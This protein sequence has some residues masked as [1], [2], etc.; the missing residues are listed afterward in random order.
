[1]RNRYY[2]LTGIIA[3]F[4]FLIT[5]LPAAPVISMFE[6]RLPVEIKNISGTFW[7]GQAASI[8]T[9][10]DLVLKNVEWSFLPWRL[11]LASA[12][13]DVSAKLNNKPINTR[14]SAG[15][16]G[17]IT[18]ADLA[19]RLDASDV[20]PLLALPIGELAG[21]FQL[22]IDS[23][24]F[25]QGEVPRVD[26]T[27]NWNRA[28]VTV[29]ETAELGNVSILV[30]E[31][32]TSPLAARISNKG[33][34]ISL[35]GNFTTTEQGDYSLQLT[36]KPSNTASDNLVKTLAMFSRKQRNGEFVLNNKGNLSQLGLM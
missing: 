33:G 35:N 36:M 16:N 1:M 7:N 13:V 12:A 23:A 18:V 8:D 10:R 11:L 21:E 5:S 22:H 3:Y 24:S 2:I 26:G 25:K 4:V 34:D 9:R 31:E 19:L 17:K 28:A 20:Q 6:H 14:L 32:D 27:I 29:A 30:N 15:I